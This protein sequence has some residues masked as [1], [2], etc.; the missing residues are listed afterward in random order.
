MQKRAVWMCP[1]T[2]EIGKKSA[3][4]LAFRGNADH[5][6]ISDGL[7]L[8]QRQCSFQFCDGLA[9]H[10]ATRRER[11]LEAEIKLSCHNWG[12]GY[13]ALDTSIGKHGVDQSHLKHCQV[14]RGGFESHNLSQ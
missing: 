11:M 9:S 5:R 13:R 10:D 7:S 2:L 14:L 8:C 6:G 12:P 1:L 4:Q 3:P